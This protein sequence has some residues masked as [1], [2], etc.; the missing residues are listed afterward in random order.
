[1]GLVPV[2]VS[3]KLGLYVASSDASERWPAA[4]L[5]SVLSLLSAFRS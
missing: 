5:H 4:G 1:M 2:E 3:S